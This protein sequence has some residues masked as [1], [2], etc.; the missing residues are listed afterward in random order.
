MAVNEK[1]FKIREDAT[2]PTLANVIIVLGKEDKKIYDIDVV[3]VTEKAAEYMQ[4]LSKDGYMG[5]KRVKSKAKTK[6]SQVSYNKEDYFVAYKIAKKL[7]IE[8]MKEDKI[9]KNKIVISTGE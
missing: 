6:P 8:N 2:I 1:Y 9:T 3:G 7:G 5:L 4:T